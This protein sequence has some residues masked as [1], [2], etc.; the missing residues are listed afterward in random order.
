M[1]VFC[2]SDNLS[3][4]L[5]LRNVKKLYNE[6]KEYHK[7]N[8]ELHFI[9]INGVLKEV[10]DLKKTNYDLMFSTN[11]SRYTS[12]LLF[13]DNSRD[14]SLHLA[15]NI[16]DRII[17][18]KP[19][20][21]KSLIVTKRKIFLVCSSEN[22]YAEV[23]RSLLLKFGTDLNLQESR[24]SLVFVKKSSAT[25]LSFNMNGHISVQITNNRNIS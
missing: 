10:I 17:V 4:V 9:R 5:L 13:F 16:S 23:L 7:G 8:D 24:E 19:N 21:I 18:E 20:E 15:W 12:K 22:G 2:T 1:R 6:L 14:L 25:P 3:V 11:D